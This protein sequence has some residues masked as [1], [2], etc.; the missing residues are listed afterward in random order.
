M[1]FIT[2]VRFLHT[3]SPIQWMFSQNFVYWWFGTGDLE[4][5]YQQQQCWSTHPW[6]SRCLWV[7]TPRSTQSGRY[8]ANDIFEFIFL[9]QNRTFIKWIFEPVMACFIDA[10]IC[11]TRHQWVYCLLIWRK[12]SWRVVTDLQIQ[13]GKQF[14]CCIWLGLTDIFRVSVN[15]ESGWMKYECTDSFYM[16]SYFK[17]YLLTHVALVKH[18]CT[19]GL[20]SCGIVAYSAPSHSWVYAE[21]LSTN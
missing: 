21:L 13:I 2:N 12:K 7:N 10:Y 4:S 15:L 16:M 18:I 14:L 20:G 19:I 17:V 1:V 6:V 5:G 11:V 8:F 3:I 9:N